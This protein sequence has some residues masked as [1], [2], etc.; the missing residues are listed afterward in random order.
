MLRRF[1]LACLIVVAAM[2]TCCVSAERR[3]V[4]TLEEAQADPDFAIQGEYLGEGT[5]PEKGRCK[6]GAQ[7]IARGKGKFEAYILLGGLPGEGW[8]RGDPR[9]RL[10]GQR[11]DGQ[12]VLTGDG[13]SATIAEGKLRINCEKSGKTFVLSR[14]ERK[15]PTLGAKPPKG[16]VVLLNGDSSEWFPG[17]HPGP[18]GSIFSGATSKAAFDSYLLHLEFRLTWMPEARG[19]GR[20]NSGVYI[21]NC[22]EIQVLDSFGL[23][24]RDNECGGLYSI[25]A[26]DVNACLPPMVWQTYDVEFTAPKYD[27]D[28]KKVANARLTVQHNGIVI[29]DDLELPRATPGGQGEGPGPR[30]IMLQG[31]GCHVHY[32][33]IWLVPK[34]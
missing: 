5:L 28:G 33:N 19:Q 25:K 12:V 10:E 8:K 6:I 29:H 11:K 17:A 27:K 26:P 14:V 20:S 7:V 24:G 23:E 9:V 30:A 31:H 2:R 3:E 15:S 34:K 1:L 22:Y 13:H 18:E 32:R 21:H 4:W 16:A